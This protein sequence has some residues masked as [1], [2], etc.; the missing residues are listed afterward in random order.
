MILVFDFIIS[1]L[2][3]SYLLNK[4]QITFWVSTILT[5][6]VYVVLKSVLLGV[7]L[8][9]F[10]LYF[11]KNIIYSSLIINWIFLIFFAF[12]YNKL[13]FK[14]LFNIKEFWIYNTLITFWFLSVVSL[15][16][17]NIIPYWWDELMY[18]LPITVELLHKWSWLSDLWLSYYWHNNI[19]QWY[20][21]NLYFVM[22]YFFVLTKNIIWFQIYWIFAFLFIFF[23]T[24]KLN[25]YLFLKNE[26]KNN[27]LTLL[28]TILSLCVPVIFLHLFVKVDILFFALIILFIYNL[29]IFS[30]IYLLIILWLLIIWFK[31]LW[32]YFLVITVLSY[33]IYLSIFESEKLK[34]IF[35]EINKNKFKII[36]F[37]VLFSV[38]FLYSFI[39]NQL[40]N[41]NFLYPINIIHLTNSW[42]QENMSVF[43]W[44]KYYLRDFIFSDYYNYF[45]K[46]W[47]LTYESSWMYNYDRWL[48]IMWFLMIVWMYLY[49]LFSAKKTNKLNNFVFV[50]ILVFLVISFS[51]LNIIFWHRYQIFIYSLLVFLLSLNI[52]L[53]S[54]NNYKYILTVIIL[55]NIFLSLPYVWAFWEKWSWIKQL[56][57]ITKSDYCS[58]LKNIWDISRDDYRNWWKYICE[59][60]DNKNILA[61][62]QV[63]NFYLYWKNFNN[64]LF[65]ELFYS[66]KDFFD[67]ID[68]K[69]I[70]YIITSNKNNLYSEFWIFGNKFYAN[71]T[72]YNDESVM[73][74]S[75]TN[76]K[77][78]KK[79]KLDYKISWK[80]DIKLNFWINNYEINKV[81]TWKQTVIDL[82][83]INITNVC[84]TIFDTPTKSLNNKEKSIDFIKDLTFI[85]WNWVKSTLQGLDFTF[86]ETAIE[87]IWLKNAWYKK[88]FIDNF[89]DIDYFYLWKK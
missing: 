5:F 28:T 49:F 12:N 11:I 47:I 22:D 60:V 80:D 19:R 58:K 77:N 79:I 54:K 63:F 30:N 75:K 18:H 48:W 85:D 67:F 89:N 52:F 20:P 40:K 27:T 21:K 84:L 2:I 42:L 17:F 39:Y 51:K 25:S 74:C 73:F 10:W 7:F 64:N 68:S 70:D 1:V 57:S 46:S 88:I 33:L 41:W 43:Y 87:D 78:I 37:F 13:S 45:L 72:D 26:V 81:L 32:V 61:I 66:K 69:K 9:F 71:S 56:F 24:F 3:S 44:I 4:K 15:A 59:N 82:N 83:N 55:S 50:L 38:I 29:F 76:L 16:I 62:N 35:L 65:N 6:F 86:K 34:N 14:N 23:A 53:L 8:W 36:P 31:I